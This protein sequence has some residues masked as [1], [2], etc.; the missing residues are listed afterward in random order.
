MKNNTLTRPIIRAAIFSLLAFAVPT[1]LCVLRAADKSAP[2][3][4]KPASAAAS[5]PQLAKEMIGTWVLVGKPGK[6]G[7]P[8][9][10]GGRLK[11]R[12]GR[13][14]TMTQANPDTGLTVMHDGGTYTLDGDK[15]VETIEYANQSTANDIGKSFMF[16][17]KVEG[18]TMTQTGIGNPY[19]EV[20]K[21]LK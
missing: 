14:W 17:V 2:A 21:R 3:A 1:A 19:T 4:D 12:T 5:A 16:T 9:A 7:E 20:W 11:F 13:H 15:Y 6:V 18:D 8:P 10:A